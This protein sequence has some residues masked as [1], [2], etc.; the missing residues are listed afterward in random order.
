M[1][2]NKKLNPYHPEVLGKPEI[3]GQ[4]LDLGIGRSRFQSQIWPL[5]SHLGGVYHDVHPKGWTTVK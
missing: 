3:L 1:L 2:L 5:A 4:T